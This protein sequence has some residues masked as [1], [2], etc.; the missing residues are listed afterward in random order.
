MTGYVLRFAIV[1]AMMISL[2][3]GSGS[4]ISQVQIVHATSKPYESSNQDKVSKV[5]SSQSGVPV[6]SRFS[7]WQSGIAVM[8]I[9]AQAKMLVIAVAFAHQQQEE[10]LRTIQSL[11]FGATDSVASYYRQVSYGQFDLQGN[12]VG[13]PLHSGQFLSLPHTESYYAGL[14]NGSGSP[15]PNDDDGIVNDAISLLR[16]DG[17]NFQPYVENGQIPYLSLVFTGYGADVDSSDAALVWPVESTLGKSIRVPYLTPSRTAKQGQHQTATGYALLSNYDLVPELA[18][19]SGA[20]ST[21]GVY[22]HEFGHLLGLDDLY[23]TSSSDQV[24]QGDGSWSIMAQGNWNGDP[25]GS[26][27]AQLDPLSRILLGWVTPIVIHESITGLTIPPLETSPVVYALMPAGTQKDYFLL[28]NVEPISDDV[29]LPSFGLL[30]WHIDGSM[31]TFSSS[32]WINNVLNSPSQNK[33]HHY[34]VLVEEANGSQ[35]L[36]SASGENSPGTDTYPSLTNNRFTAS[37]KPNNILWDGKSI[38]INLT[39]IAVNSTKT[40]SLDVEDKQSGASLVV[41]RPTGGLNVL[42]TQSITLHVLYTTREH[43]IDV[44]HEGVFSVMAGGATL[45]GNV[46][47]FSNDGT[48]VISVFAKHLTS[49]IYLHVVG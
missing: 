8:P 38:G 31:A 3:T 34:D 35:N 23:D 42:R 41:A 10:S 9:H 45:H 43:T 20:P 32:D 40:V 27:P 11:Y 19:P 15:Y 28:D 48:V 4:F 25:Q 13:N 1:F 44:S 37:S 17:F 47:T 30:I 18:D 14:D 46:A 29:A 7:P 12:V 26:Q 16:H 22:A 2:F 21:I 6:A 36:Q 39:N 33:T 49:L 24:G 5:T